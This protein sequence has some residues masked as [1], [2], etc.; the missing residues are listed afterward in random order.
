MIT[1][2]NN[3]AP[4]ERTIEE[5]PRSGLATLDLRYQTICGKGIV[6]NESQ[7]TF[8]VSLP[9]IRQSDLLC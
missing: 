4:I 6:V 8:A 9:V 5:S 7:D 3:R 1:V 2:S